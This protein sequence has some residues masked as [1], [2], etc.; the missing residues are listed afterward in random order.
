[1]WT[2]ISQDE[3]WMKKGKNLRLHKEQLLLIGNGRMK[4]LKMIGMRYHNSFR[5]SSKEVR[6]IFR[7]VTFLNQKE[8]QSWIRKREKGGKGLTSR[9]WIKALG[10]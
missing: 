10:N 6:K 1:V 4:I 2:S 5:I 9:C 3:N 8:I 7:V